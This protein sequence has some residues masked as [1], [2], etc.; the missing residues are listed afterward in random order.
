MHHRQFSV[1]DQPT[2]PP[3][4]PSQ[5]RDGRVHAY[6]YEADGHDCEVALDEACIRDLGERSLLWVDVGARDRQTLEHLARLFNLDDTSVRELL[7]SQD[8]LYLDNYGEYFQFDVVAL[9]PSDD[10]GH[11]KLMPG[12]NAVHLEFLVGPRWIITVHDG[13]LPFL[14]AFREQDKG[15]TLIGAL[16]PPALVASLLDWHLTAYF[17]ALAGHEAFL[18]RLDEVIL[19]RS[20]K[21]SLLS[22]VVEVRRRVSRLRRL[23]AAQRL[24]FYGLSRPDFSHVVESDAASH[25]RSLERRFERAVDAVD[26]SRDLVNGSFD[27]FT[28]RTAEA[29]NDL[30]R[31]L[32]FV[33]VL[34][35]AISAIAGIFGMN[36]EMPYKQAGVLEFWAVVGILVTLSTAATL[37]A[38]RRGW[39]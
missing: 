25:Y 20:A 38:R 32:T 31:R 33:T 39:I 16:S 27:L 22:G 26:H 15:E 28:T 5:V 29:T 3:P 12:H 14:E 17:E 35:G 19:T 24:V 9:S 37:F 23:L 10:N 13:D 30:V 18:D 6:L 2:K 21:Q 36:F 1:N 34:L 4:L 8:D 11:E 7:R